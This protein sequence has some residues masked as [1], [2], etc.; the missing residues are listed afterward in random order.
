MFDQ[1]NITG[2][3]DVKMDGSLLEEES[4][5]KIRGILPF[6][7]KL[8][9]GSFTIYVDKIVCDK[10]GVLIRSMIFFPLEV[11]LYFY[12]STILP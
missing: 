6:S 8:D 12:K 2:A 11:V 9:C 4:S 7:S 5:F 3:I 10:I 1:Y